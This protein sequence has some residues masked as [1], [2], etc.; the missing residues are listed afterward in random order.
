M[1]FRLS[2]RISSSGIS[3]PPRCHPCAAM[4]PSQRQSR[5][6]RRWLGTSSLRSRQPAAGSP[7]GRRRRI[8]APRAP[9]AI[10]RSMSRHRGHRHLS[11]CPP[12]RA[13]IAV[14]QAGR[15][16]A[17]PADVA[18]HRQAM[19]LDELGPGVRQ[20]AA[21][22]NPEREAAAANTLQ[23]ATTIRPPNQQAAS[24]A[25]RQLAKQVQ[26]NPG[27]GTKIRLQYAN[28]VSPAVAAAFKQAGVDVTGFSHVVD[29]D[30]VRHVFA[31]HGDAA[32][33]LSRGQIPV[34]PDD[35]AKLPQIMESP[36]EVTP[37][38]PTD[39]GLPA[40]L[41]KKQIGNNVYVVQEARVGK[42]QLAVTSMW[43]VGRR[44]QM[45]DLGAPAPDLNVRDGGDTTGA[46][47]TTATQNAAGSAA[48]SVPRST[49]QVLAQRSEPLSAHTVAHYADDTGMHIVRSR[50]GEASAQESGPYLR[51][52]RIDVNPASRGKGEAT[53]MMER[54]LQAAQERGLTLG[55]DISV[56]PDQRKV[57]RVL[58]SRG[59]QVKQNPSSISPTTKNLVSDDIR[60]PVYEV[61]PPVRKGF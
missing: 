31:Q 47:S 2:P 44:G 36:D 38:R 57:Y 37:T 16:G 61:R 27:D 50:N 34:T 51:V 32:T 13:P 21:G 59:W 28:Q 11:R 12:T 60:V 49:N 10:S 41:V 7:S 22:P 5:S 48:K 25:L 19:G 23:A 4:C 33:E 54:L 29:A 20:P 6:G 15:A 39:R 46:E 1:D 45:P 43:K 52:E 53:A 35:F 55:S 30:Q 3:L 18:A 26:G 56:S 42:K 40:V 14:D 17:S 24:K 9:P 8:R 58:G